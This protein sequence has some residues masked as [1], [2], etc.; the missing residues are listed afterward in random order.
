M[1]GSAVCGD[2]KSAFDCCR[3]SSVCKAMLRSGIE[4]LTIAAWVKDQIAMT[5]KPDFQGLEA[6]ASDFSGI[7]RQGGEDGPR[8]WNFVMMMIF[9]MLGQCWESQSTAGYGI[10][11]RPNCVLTHLIWSDNIVLFARDEGHLASMI[12]QTTDVFNAH[13]LSWKVSDFALLN[14]GDD[15]FDALGIPRDEEDVGWLHIS[16]FA[17]PRKS[18]IPLLG[19]IVSDNGSTDAALQSSLRKGKRAFWKN[20]NI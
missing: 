7:L 14:G 11:L 2:V 5:L 20:K 4:P 15:S 8:G 16:G 6:K 19:S 9:D 17:I 10:Q 12:K 18:G 13:H 3:L 1:E